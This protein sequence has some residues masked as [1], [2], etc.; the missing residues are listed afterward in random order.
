MGSRKIRAAAI[1]AALAV[2]AVA[3]GSA[4]AFA[5]Q[6]LDESAQKRL[7]QSVEHGAQVAAKGDRLNGGQSISGEDYLVSP[8]GQH[9]LWADED[10]Y[11]ISGSGGLE[12]LTGDRVIP[13]GNLRLVMQGDGN[14]VLYHGGQALFH[15]GTNGNPGAYVQMQNDG[16]LVVRSTENAALWASR[17]VADYGFAFTEGTDR[18]NGRMNS[19]WYLTS[20]NGKFRLVMQGDGNLV[21]YSGSRALWHTGTNGNPGAYFLVQADGNL[22]VYSSAN[23]ALWHSRT[24]RNVDAVVLVMQNDANLVSYG[25]IGDDVRVLWHSVT[26]GRG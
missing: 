20:R 3:G 16:N 17:T 23:K 1:T 24:V 11:I 6:Q 26:A 19:G 14:L 25:F 4:P 18:F 10:L 7:L 12:I 8:S 22:V 13:E 9:E 15:T 2:S 5:T 21:L